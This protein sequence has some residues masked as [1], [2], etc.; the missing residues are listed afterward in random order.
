MGADDLTCSPFNVYRSYVDL[1][2]ITPILRGTVLFCLAKSQSGRS[3]FVYSSNTHIMLAGPR[4][5]G[6]F[7]PLR[8]YIQD[9]FPNFEKSFGILVGEGAFLRLRSP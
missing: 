2:E 3:G 7:D 6:I 9:I 8:V 5:P 4:L 1:P